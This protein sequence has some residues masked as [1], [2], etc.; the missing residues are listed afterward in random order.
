MVL[1]QKLLKGCHQGQSNIVLVILERLKFEKKICRPTIVADNIF[2]CS[3]TLQ[4]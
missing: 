1:K 2:Q 3:M 4:L